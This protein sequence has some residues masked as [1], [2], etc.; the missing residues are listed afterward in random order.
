MG[1]AQVVEL[2]SKF[3]ALDIQVDGGVGPSNI[4]A[5]AA[6][7]ANVIVAGTSVFEAP[8]PAGAIATLRASVARH[9]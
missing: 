7:G 3:P 8:D 6:A 2:R 9:C 5:A 4:D 1:P